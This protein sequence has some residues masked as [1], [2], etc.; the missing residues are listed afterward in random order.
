MKA[1]ATGFRRGLATMWAV[2]VLALMTLILAAITAQLL[3]TRRILEH[4]QN[5]LQAIWLAR[6]GLELA[7][8]RLLTNPAGYENEKLELVPQSQVKIK[9]SKGDKPDIF[10][11]TSEV[12]YPLDRRDKIVRT[13]TRRFQRTVDK[14]QAR[15]SVVPD[16]AN[17]E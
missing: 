4:R 5:E 14:G 17:K 13:L 11:V 9:V 6:S 2:M 15:L 16:A 8:Q 3:S 7:G 12:S 1:T 10:V